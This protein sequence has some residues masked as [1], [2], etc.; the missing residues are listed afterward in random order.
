[1]ISW[2]T[3]YQ[4]LPIKLKE[5]LKENI[6]DSSDFEIISKDFNQVIFCSKSTGTE[7]SYFVDIEGSTLAIWFADQKDP[8]YTENQ[9]YI[10][11]PY[12]RALQLMQEGSFPV[13]SSIYP[14]VYC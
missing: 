4:S 13:Q 1:M 3:F 12:Y 11:N 2:L 5:Y 6:G 7:V 14:D 8:G 10:E 9:L